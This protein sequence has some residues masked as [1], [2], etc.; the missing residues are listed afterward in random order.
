MTT[1][2]Q[3]NED[4]VEAMNTRIAF[5]ATPTERRKIEF[6]AGLEGTTVSELV[7]S[8]VLPEVERRR[9]ELLGKLER[10]G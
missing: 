10:I 2:A 9:T 7:H 3:E 4:R 8:I 5:A 6:I 1:A